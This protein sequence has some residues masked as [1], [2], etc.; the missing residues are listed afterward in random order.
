MG[1]DNETPWE[2]VKRWSE[3]F[4]PR[5]LLAIRCH[6]TWRCMLCVQCR[7]DHYLCVCVC[8][9]TSIFVGT[10][11]PNRPYTVR[12]LWRVTPLQRAVWGLSLGFRVSVRVGYQIQVRVR[13]GLRPLVLMVSECIMSMSVYSHRRSVNHPVRSLLAVKHHAVRLLP[14][15]CSPEKPKRNS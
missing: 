5:C 7:S 11:L 9:C 8:T 14:L 15:L 12:T 13:V 4:R 3:I 6:L 2:E 10:L 1:R